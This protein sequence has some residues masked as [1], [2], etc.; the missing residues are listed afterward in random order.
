MRKRVYLFRVGDLYKIGI[1]THPNKRAERLSTKE[2]IVEV[3]HVIKAWHA[4]HLE[5]ALHYRFRHR[6]VGGE[7][8]RLSEEDVG[9]VLGIGDCDGERDLPDWMVPDRWKQ[10]VLNVTIP[11]DLLERLQERVREM[12]QKYRLRYNYRGEI[13]A[14]A[15]E[16][17]LA[18]PR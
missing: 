4:Q 1:S 3:L 5:R 11:A 18:C 15:L 10:A 8:F 16:A 7:W 14:A 17:Y 9:L 13:V 6:S 2:S 12:E